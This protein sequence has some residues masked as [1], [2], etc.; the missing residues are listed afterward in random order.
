[1][2]KDW[3]GNAKEIIEIDGVRYLLEKPLRPKFALVRADYCDK[4]GNFTMLRATKNFNH[5]MAM[6]AEHTLLASEKVYEI[7]EKDPDEYQF[8][9][10]YVEKIV[11]GEKPWEI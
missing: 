5:V 1:M 7:G 11:E 6:A 2:E 8:S 10:V 4:Y 3:Q 9:G